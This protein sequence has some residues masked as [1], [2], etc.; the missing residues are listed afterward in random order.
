MAARL[1]VLGQELLQEAVDQGLDQELFADDIPEFPGVG[2]PSSGEDPAI[3]QLEQETGQ[4]LDQDGEQGED[5]EM[6]EDLGNLECVECLDVPESPMGLPQ[7][8][9]L[10]GPA[11]N[12]PVSGAGSDKPKN[13]SRRYLACAAPTLT[14]M[15]DGRKVWMS[16]CAYRVPP[17]RRVRML[18]KIVGTNSS[19]RPRHVNIGGKRL[20]FSTEAELDRF[21]V[22]DG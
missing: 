1:S 5:E 11:S 3:E 4:D 6:F 7:D 8:N 2:E 13:R 16:V 15:K 19:F 17:N 22:D 21:L 18:A 10:T 14:R 20:T 9:T 12:L